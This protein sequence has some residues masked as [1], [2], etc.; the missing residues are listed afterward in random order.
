[1]CFLYACSLK[2]M[3]VGGGGGGGGVELTEPPIY[4]SR[5]SMKFRD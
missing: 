2:I 1:M 5:S 3:G 4:M